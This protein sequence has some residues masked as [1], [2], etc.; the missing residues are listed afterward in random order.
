MM[1]HIRPGGFFF[2]PTLIGALLLLVV[3]L[4]SGPAAF[5]TAALLVLLE[6]TLSFDNAVVNAKVLKDM[7]PK[8]QQR[9]LTWGILF[10][11][12]GTRVIL[13]IV[14]VAIV[15]G[16]SPILVAN[17]AMFSP[18]EYGH[19]LHD[20]HHAISAFGAAFLFMVS[21]KFFFDET[22]DVH[23]I[24]SVEKRLAHWG[25]IE[26]FEIALVLLLLFVVSF[27]VPAERAL[28]LSAGII[29]VVIFVFME[30]LTHALSSNVK[31]VAHSGLAGFL[32]LNVLDSAFSLDG[33]IGAFAITTDLLTIAVGLGIGAYF[34]RSMTVYLV[35]E[36]TLS[37]LKYLEHGAHWA[38]F[39]LAASMA[40]SLVTEVPEV[41]TAGIGIIFI[42]A[43]YR[44]S[45][46]DGPHHHS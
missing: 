44:S 22:K 3:L 24:Q 33:V 23:W 17:L 41:V 7:S 35:K 16:L 40:L 27:F 29:G 13:P 25:N 8:W 6:V 36:G 38:I 43:A 20:S 34:V 39:G 14:I 5:F 12:V 2:Y 32:Y 9:F 28:I 4:G 21:L 37:A 42:G 11:V 30:G 19:M 10:A 46:A 45:L 18:A 31:S 1:H 15:A 26:A